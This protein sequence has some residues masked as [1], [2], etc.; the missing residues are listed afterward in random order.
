M[1]LGIQCGRDEQLENSSAWWGRDDAFLEQSC[2]GVEAGHEEAAALLRTWGDKSKAQLDSK[3]GS[4]SLRSALRRLGSLLS[5]APEPDPPAAT[6]THGAAQDSLARRSSIL[7][8]CS[9]PP[10]APLA[11]SRRRS[12]P[13]P[14]TRHCPHRRKT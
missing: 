4:L 10:P 13:A 1:L 11:A 6:A 8:T 9:S 3:L 5:S 12:A 2:E 14:S 7:A